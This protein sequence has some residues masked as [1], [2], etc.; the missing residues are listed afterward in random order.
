[1]EKFHA[2]AREVS[3][4]TY[5]EKLLDAGL[6]ASEDFREHIT[7]LAEADAARGYVLFHARKP[8]AYVFCP[9]VNGTVVYQYVGFD[10]DYR[11]QSPG[12]VLQY[13]LLESLFAEGKFRLFDFTEGEGPHKELFSTESVACADLYFL[14]PTPSNVFLVALYVV[15]SSVSK[16]AVSLLKKLNIHRRVKALIRFGWKQNA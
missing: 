6:P 16:A 4:R 10:P 3:S 2:A 7:R 12:T 15:V 5:Q 11:E 1:M 8:I 14:R 13:V 9:I